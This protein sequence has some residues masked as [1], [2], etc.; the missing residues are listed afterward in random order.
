MG[1]LLTNWEKNLNIQKRILHTTPCLQKS[2]ENKKEFYAK[3]LR[4]YKF[5]KI[6]KG[7]F[8]IK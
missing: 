6:L 2:F 3:Q 8:K 1:K 4:T 5:K 7:E